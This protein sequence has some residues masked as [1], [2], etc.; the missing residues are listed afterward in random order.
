MSQGTHRLLLA[1]SWLWLLAVIGYMAWSTF[2]FEGLYRWLAEWEM[3][4]WG[5]YYRK[6]TAT[7]PVLI[8]G[9]PAFIYLGRRSRQRT[10]AE[11]ASPAAQARRMRRVALV[12]LVIGLLGAGIGGGAFWLSQG[13]PDGNEPAA[14][15]D[16][17]RLGS[18][19]A[20]DTKV[21]LE[22]RLDPEAS[23]G[24]ARGGVED[25]VTYY[26][27]FR[28]NDDAKNA[29]VR[30]FVERGTRPETL[31]TMQGFLPEQTG[32]LVENG[33][34]GRALDELRARGVRVASPHYL[35]RTRAGAL[36]EPYYVTAAVAG[37]LGL[38]CL[39][40]GLAGLL[41]ARRRAWLATAIRPDGSP[42]EQAPRA[43]AVR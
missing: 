31:N 1:L 28:A 29:P 21:R 5:Q 12:L 34:P 9:M 30:L 2:A 22:G 25:S 8:L 19:P 3:A 36:R 20:P 16:L 32:Y 4:Q 26:A 27:A 10:A 24:L 43:D 14:P 40:I 18:G 41:Q 23:T 38:V 11:A 35:L 15:F 6:W 17:A 37:F 42:G 33:V 39:I 7:L 13:L